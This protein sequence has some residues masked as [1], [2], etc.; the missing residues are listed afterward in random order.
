MKN[1][2]EKIIMKLQDENMLD[3]EL[4]FENMRNLI[5]QINILLEKK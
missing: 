4:V 1:R 3:G 2:V 5:K